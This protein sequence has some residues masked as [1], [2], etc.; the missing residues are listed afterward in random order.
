MLPWI[1][2]VRFV[3]FVQS[4]FQGEAMRSSAPGSN[5]SFA[6]ALP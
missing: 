2:F 3:V 4:G 5:S 1:M 6:S